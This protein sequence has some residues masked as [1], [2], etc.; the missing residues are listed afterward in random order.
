M[1]ALIK[2][3]RLI[4][5]NL[6]STECWKLKK[7]CDEQAMRKHTLEHDQQ[8]K[9]IGIGGKV[10]VRGGNSEA[11]R[12]GMACLIGEI[13]KFNPKT[14]TVKFSDTRSWRVPY[15]WLTTIDKLE[16]EK[17]SKEHMIAFQPYMTQLNK[18]VSEVLK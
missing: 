13:M 5:K 7:Y 2:V 12:Y 8:I 15:S 1:K 14:V 3:E 10:L 11:I 16:D 6:T 17:K 9:D 18:V 4:E